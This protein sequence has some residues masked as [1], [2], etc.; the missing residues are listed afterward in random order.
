[1]TNE[2]EH[3]FRLKE[4]DRLLE[5]LE[6]RK[7][8]RG[9]LYYTYP[10][11]F[12]GL[13]DFL[14][15][16]ETGDFFFNLLMHYSTRMLQEHTGDKDGI[17]INWWSEPSINYQ[18]LI[19]EI[20]DDYWASL[21]CFQNGF[22][23]QSI[24]ILRNTFELLVNLYHM[25][26]A[27]NENDDVIIRWL[28]GERGKEPM[29]SIIKSVKEIEFLRAEDISPYLMQLYTLLCMATHSHKKMMTSLTVP[30]GFW[31]KEKMMFEPFIILQTRSIFLWVVETELKMIMHF[32][33]QDEIN[34]FTQKA[35]DT[36][37]RMQENL[38]AYLP[39]IESIKKGYVIHRKQVHLNSGKSVLFSLK[40]N[41]EWEF[42]KQQIK[43]LSKE[44]QEDLQKKVEELLLCDII[45]S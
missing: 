14:S 31:V 18:L 22:T 1:M 13:F 4:A 5:K 3:E 9:K 36:I 17:K 39:L 42:K 2:Q 45:N 24:E 40:I 11:V 10:K 16:S 7:E 20:F 30:G 38:K 28:D 26:F 19:Q 23:K 41:N 27:K 33:E 6:I 25:K 43:S 8:L 29:S 44:E 37:T 15:L 32:I 35:L 34:Y 12:E 21:L